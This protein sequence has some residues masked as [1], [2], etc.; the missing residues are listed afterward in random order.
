MPNV[1]RGSVCVLNVGSSQDLKVVAIS[2]CRISSFNLHYKDHTECNG[3]F[4][5]VKLG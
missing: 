3:L 5:G 1:N 2:P 4:R